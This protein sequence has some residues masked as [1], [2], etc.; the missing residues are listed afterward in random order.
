MGRYADDTAVMT[1]SQK[2]E[3]TTH[4]LNAA[5]DELD[6]WSTQW[7]VAFNGINSNA[8]L[9]T[10]NRHS[11]YG[12]VILYWDIVHRSRHVKYIGVTNHA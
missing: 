1:K 7:R 9:C 12:S 10:R 8:V 3:I 11:P 4:N 5:A 6:A 2:S